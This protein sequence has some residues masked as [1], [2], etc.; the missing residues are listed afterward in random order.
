M[1][2]MMHMKTLWLFITFQNNDLEDCVG[3]YTQVFRYEQLK[4]K[5][6]K[7]IDITLTWYE[8]YM[9]THNLYPRISIL[10]S[11]PMFSGMRD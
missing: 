7:V 5:T 11:T 8:K 2:A 10:V 6:L 1:A 3:V 4:N 9:S